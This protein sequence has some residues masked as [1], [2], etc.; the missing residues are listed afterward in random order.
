MASVHG[1][2]SILAKARE[3]N[4]LPYVITYMSVASPTAGHLS[5]VYQQETDTSEVGVHQLLTCCSLV[6]T[7]WLAICI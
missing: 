4:P 7:R 6:P 2:Q 5:I 1:N 3:T